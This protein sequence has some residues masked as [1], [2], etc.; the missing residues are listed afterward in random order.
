MDSTDRLPVVTALTWER[1]VRPV[2]IAVLDQAEPME[3][4]GHG[5]KPIRFQ[6]ALL[7][8]IYEPN[9][10]G[11]WRIFSVVLRGPRLAGST[12]TPMQRQVEVYWEWH[13]LDRAP[14]WVRRFA[15][16]HRPVWENEEG[17]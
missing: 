8:V 3:R 14:E 16:D 12:D 9:G 4:A 17:A 2:A 10:C 6:P 11:G 13:S 1:C 5:G 15:V 7:R